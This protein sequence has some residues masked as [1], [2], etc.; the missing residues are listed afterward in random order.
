M[1]TLFTIGIIFLVFEMI[2]LALRATWGL[3]KVVFWVLGLPFVL[4]AM[5]LG[6]LLHLGMPLLVIGL[7]IGLFSLGGKH[8]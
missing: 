7:I 1:I 4:V 8:A 2:A 3:V 5:L 6:G